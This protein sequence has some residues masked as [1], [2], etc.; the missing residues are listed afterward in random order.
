MMWIC[1]CIS[2]TWKMFRYRKHLATFYSFSIR[3]YFLCNKCRGF[4]TR[5]SI[6]NWII[7]VD[8]HIRYRGKVY[9]YAYLPTFSSYLFSIFIDKRVVCDTPCIWR[10]YR[11][12]WIFKEVELQVRFKSSFVVGVRQMSF[13]TTSFTNVIKL[14][15]S[16]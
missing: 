5:A 14:L 12:N 11:G 9:M 8:V 1:I 10:I 7:G 6:D 2:M 16:C 3:H 13:A 4:A 15:I